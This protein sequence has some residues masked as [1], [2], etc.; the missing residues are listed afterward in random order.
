LSQLDEFVGNLPNNVSASID[1][2]GTN[3][4]GGQ[5]QRLGIARAVFTNPKI[6][7]LDEATAA[8]D[9]E[10]E[11]NITES[12]S[13]LHGKVTLIVI[14]H[15]L[16]TVLKADRVIYLDKGKIVAIGTFDYV[17]ESVPNFDQQAKLMGL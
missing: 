7:V 16:S 6:L 1:D 2:R 11:S 13:S 8:L 17:R 5:R 15:R 10:T 12:I 4:S 3:L 14:A 9:A